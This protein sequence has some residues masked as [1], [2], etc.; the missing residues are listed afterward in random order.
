KTFALVPALLATIVAVL[1]GYRL[2][3]GGA[4]PLLVLSGLGIVVAAGKS[5]ELHHQ[6][7][8]GFAWVGLLL[9]PAIFVPIVIA[10]LPWTTG[11]ELNVA[12]PAGAMGRFFAESF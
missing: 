12:Q 3:I 9:V 1:A 8:L 4:A 7:I 6:R 11:T 10:V 5:I 2:P